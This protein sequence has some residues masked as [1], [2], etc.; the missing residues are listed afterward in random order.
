MAV[1]AKKSANPPP[2]GL[3][4]LPAR[5]DR[6]RPPDWRV[7][8]ARAYLAE[9]AEPSVRRHVDA[10]AFELAGLLADLDDCPDRFGYQG[11]VLAAYGPLGEAYRIYTVSDASTEPAGPLCGLRTVALEIEGMVLAGADDATIAGLTGLPAEVVAAYAAAFYDVRDRLGD[12]AWVS[13]AVVKPSLDG[14]AD[15][16]LSGVVRGYGYIGKS[17]AFVLQMARTIDPDLG[18]AADLYEATALDARRSI[19]VK[20]HLVT[21]G[22]ELTEKR[23]RAMV[24]LTQ[25]YQRDDREAGSTGGEHRQL[26]AALEHLLGVRAREKYRHHP[27]EAAEQLALAAQSP[28]TAQDHQSADTVV[29]PETVG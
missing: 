16:V 26:V 6:F 13:A 12:A 17:P 25:N 18:R 22:V 19:L 11:A 14:P 4:G 1:A 8:V 29:S 23:F 15:R 2:A 7:V 21:R 9:P 24:E 27:A 3:L 10:T 5:G 20:S 28:A